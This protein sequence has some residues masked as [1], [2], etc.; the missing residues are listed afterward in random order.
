MKYFTPVLALTVLLMVGCTQENPLDAN[1]GIKSGDPNP[2][3]RGP[4]SVPYHSSL[5]T[6]FGPIIFPEQCAGFPPAEFGLVGEGVMTHLGAITSVG[7]SGVDPG[8]GEQIGCGTIIADN[9]DELWQEIRGYFEFT[10]PPPAPPIR[11][12][13]WGDVTFDGGTGRFVTATGSG[14]YSGSFDFI[15]GTGH[16]EDS[17]TLSR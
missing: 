7:V 17:G 12:D 5:N 4:K 14:T 3:P 13:F 6:S 10:P 8:T 9:G 2:I 1:S 16:V 11:V 15:T